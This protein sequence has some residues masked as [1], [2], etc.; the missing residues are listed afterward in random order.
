MPSEW[1]AVQ[2]ALEPEIKAEAEQRQKATQFK[3]GMPPSGEGKFPAPN[4]KSKEKRRVSNVVA[5][6]VGVSG[7]TLEKAKVV[8]E[9]AEKEP[10]LL[11]VNVKL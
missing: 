10:S 8:V 3:N 11:F 6:F 2:R 7:K 4:S 5:G 9:A 1:V